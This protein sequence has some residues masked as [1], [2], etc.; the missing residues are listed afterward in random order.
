M[1]IGGY[2]RGEPGFL[3]LPIEH[4]SPTGPGPDLAAFL[5]RESG[6]ER[7]RIDLL[8]AS[9]DLYWQ[10]ATVLADRMPTWPRPRIRNIGVAS[11]GT[12]LR[13]YAQVLNTSTWTL[14]HCDLDPE[15]SHSELVAFL[16]V[17]GDWMSATGEVTQAPMRAAAWWLEAGDVACASF[18][19]A[20]ER[21]AR[22]DAAAV[23]A[24]AQA[25]PW[26]RRL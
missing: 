10:R 23:R 16:L 15:L 4:L 22:P 1:R 18:A 20:A 24:V 25:L 26:L 19:A 13:P 6:W 8:S 2:C 14:Y 17:V 11:D 9:L 7:T 21:S 3:L 12:L 5:E